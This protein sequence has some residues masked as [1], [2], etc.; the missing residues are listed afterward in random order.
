[1]R[2]TLRSAKR[3]S[4]L[5]RAC[6]AETLRQ[7]VILRTLAAYAYCAVEQPRRRP[8]RLRRRV[9]VT[10]KARRSPSGVGGQ[11]PHQ[12]R[13]SACRTWH[14][15]AVRRRS[16]LQPPP[17]RHHR[18]HRRRAA[19]ER[20]ERSRVPRIGCVGEFLD[21]PARAGSQPCLNAPNCAIRGPSAIVSMHP[22]AT[23]SSNGPPSG[24]TTTW[25]DLPGVPVL[26]S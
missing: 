22:S 3:R 15:T 18:G 24:S 6:H 11:S 2:A 21:L 10:P 17:P 9:G 23:A 14:A 1:M 26:P 19:A 5:R 12:R 7:S 25:H 4:P 13:T 16:S 20:L 8:G